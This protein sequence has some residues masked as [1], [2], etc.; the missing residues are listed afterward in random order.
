MLRFFAAMLSRLRSSIS[1]S[2]S[3]RRLCRHA[4]RAGVFVLVEGRHDIEFLRSI[5]L[6][7]HTS[8]RAI[9][10]LGDMERRGE[11]V[12]VPT[13]GCDL[14][15]WLF[16][17]AGS[18]WSEFHI[19]DRDMPPESQSRHRLAEIVNLRPGCRA[20][21][22]GL[23]GL[24]NYLHPDAIFE[25]R[26]VRVVF[27]SDDNVA[28]VVARACHEQNGGQPP[29]DQLPL[30]ARKRRQNHAKKWLNTSAV[31][32]MTPERLAERDPAGEIRAWLLAIAQLAGRRR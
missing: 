31:D 5:S 18:G 9:P 12:F 16:R 24:E 8:E 4:A 21:L 23:R 19:Y 11:V 14:Q 20:V 22:T 13:G 29:W 30:R 17:L 27:S 1:R 3:A 26:S 10:D 15:F 6:M 7:L 28:N 2:G 32:R 25:A